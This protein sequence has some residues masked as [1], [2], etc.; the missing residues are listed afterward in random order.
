MKKYRT[1]LVVGKFCPLHKGHESVI[2]QALLNCEEVIVLSYTSENYPK[3]TVE[4]RRDW[5]NDLAYR[6]ED[7]MPGAA[8]RL[9]IH[10][11]DP[12]EVDIPNDLDPDEDHRKFC[13][14]YLLNVIE[15]TVQAVFN[16]ES[17]GQGFAD[18]LT[19]YFT[20]NFKNPIVVDNVLVDVDRKKYPVSGTMLR[21]TPEL[22]KESCSNVVINSY[23]KKILFL[24]GESSGK[25]TIVEALTAHYNSAQAF[26][27]GRRWF[28]IRKGLLKYEDMEYIA[29]K[30][31]AMENG[32]SQWANKYLFCDTSALT[33]SFYSNEWFLRVSK[34]LRKMVS[35]SMTRYDKIYV[36][37][38]DFPMVQDGTRQD[39]AFRI[40]GFE[41]VVNY[42][43]ATGVKYTLL[44]GSKEERLNRVVE[45]LT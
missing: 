28:D 4:N 23:V 39:E 16:S 14:D 38:P 44:G 35:D 15:T 9:K 1:G 24:G 10:V 29:R 19:L 2:E 3:C 7:Y 21:D 5:L 40:K 43:E 18:Y 36:C 31:I 27:F 34:K 26:E 42:L 30:Q 22:I 8:D 17:Y 13:G 33:T 45:D 12:K 6:F 25:T 37:M 20:V 41:F 11:L 32:Q